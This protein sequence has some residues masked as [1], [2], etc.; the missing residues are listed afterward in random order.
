MSGTR[1]K[2][3]TTR[4]CPCRQHS[5]STAE[6]CLPFSRLRGSAPRTVSTAPI[7]WRSNMA[8]ISGKGDEQGK[9]AALVQLAVDFQ[10]TAVRTGHLLHERQT[11]SAARNL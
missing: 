11:D 5:S 8:H 7:F 2:S 6:N 9:L 3:T 10:T 1:S 4:G